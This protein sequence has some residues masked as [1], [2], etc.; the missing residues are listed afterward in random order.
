MTRI[1]GLLG[2]AILGL[3][4]ILAAATFAAPLGYIVDP[5][6][7][8]L[9][10]DTGTDAV[11]G[12][13]Q[14]PGLDGSL[15]TRAGAT[16]GSDAG[17]SLPA[18]GRSLLTPGAD[19][20]VILDTAPRGLRGGLLIDEGPSGRVYVY[21][22]ITGARLGQ[23]AVPVR[24]GERLAGVDSR[25]DKAYLAADAAREGDMTLTV[26]SLTEFRVLRE[27]IVPRGDLCLSPSTGETR[28]GDVAVGR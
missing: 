10:L 3:S 5:A 11:V 8:I 9:L 2:L 28:P 15:G 14:V 27:L 23:V 4:I 17:A 18:A 13:R 26:L 16:A 7:L 22:V 6:G 25:G 24:G 12:M 21:D 1:A 20:I 19:R